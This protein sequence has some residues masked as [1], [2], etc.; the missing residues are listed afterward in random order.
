MPKSINYSITKNV[1]RTQSY[2]A[3]IGCMGKSGK[4]NS[5]KDNQKTTSL[6]YCIRY[7]NPLSKDKVK[8][9]IP[10][11]LYDYDNLD[12]KKLL[13]SKKSQFLLFLETP[14]M[15]RTNET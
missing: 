3:E 5:S 9:I 6:S 11:A 13:P 1:E 12:S 14:R 4:G 7:D 10:E 8:K 15:D 2:G